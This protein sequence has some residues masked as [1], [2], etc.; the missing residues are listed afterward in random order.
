[1]VQRLDAAGAIDLGKLALHEFALGGPSFDLPWPPARNP[2]DTSRFTQGSS[3]GTAAAIAAGL[4]LGGPGT[5][6]AGSIRAPA[7][8]CGLA[9]LKPTSGLISR[10]GVVPLS[11]TLD[12]V[13][14]MAWTVEDCALLLQELVGFDPH[15]P[16]STEAPACDYRQAL[17]GGVRG[18][19]IGVISHFH[20]RDHVVDGETLAAIQAALATF[21]AL[22]AEVREISLS[23][24]GDYAAV[25]GV[26]MIGEAYRAHA[27]TL[28]HR[29]E[30]FGRIFRNRVSAGIFYDTDD[31][32]RAYGARERLRDAFNT[33][34]ADVDIVVTA[35]L[36]AAAPPID[37]VPAWPS[38]ERP[39]LMTP[40][41][42]IGCPAMAIC[43]GFTAGGLPLSL[44]IA[45]RAFDEAT[46]LRAAHAYEQATP[47][48][49]RRPPLLS[50]SKQDPHQTNMVGAHGGC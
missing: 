25:G 33:E 41:N 5:D 13:G 44:Q 46:V 18:L 21:Q 1:M 11:P 6:T 47:W 9:G 15:D 10:A 23:P 36:P 34:I 35:A 22:G 32:R 7:A 30:D 48:R 2:W 31:L 45:G 39:S 26:I 38:I 3:S 24:L 37:K 20:E 4:I 16:A 17:E 50:S 49:Q 27:A 40:F 8:A 28:H 29:P 14:P 19:R 43:C 12:C 42:L